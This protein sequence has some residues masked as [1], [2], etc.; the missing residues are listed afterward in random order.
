MHSR[1]SPISSRKR[2]ITTVRSLGI[3][4]VAACCSRRKSTRLPAASSSRWYSSVSVAG[5]WSTAQRAKAPIAWPS[6]FG[7]PR[8]S[9]FQNGTAAGTP[10]AG[11]TITR[12]RVIS[13]IRQ[14][15]APSRK[16]CPGRAS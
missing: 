4:R 9:P 15:E 8:P 5:S 7:R 14:L 11:E 12:S 1:Q 13:S 6:S 3:T 10:G 16:V 2:S